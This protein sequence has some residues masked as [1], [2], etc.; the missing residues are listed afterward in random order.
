M[1]AVI[2]YLIAMAVCAY[3]ILYII[4]GPPLANRMAR[5]GGRTI[6]TALGAALRWPF[7]MLS[8]M[9]RRVWQ[10]RQQQTKY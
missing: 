9:L 4:G 1:T 5:R 7:S 2:A 10:S 6:M 8:G 3:G